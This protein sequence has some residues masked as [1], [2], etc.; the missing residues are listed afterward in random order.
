[1]RHLYKDP[2]IFVQEINEIIEKIITTYLEH[3]DLLT[4]FN[5]ETTLFLLMMKKIINLLIPPIPQMW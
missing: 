2:Q 1:M 5:Y 3:E 4:R